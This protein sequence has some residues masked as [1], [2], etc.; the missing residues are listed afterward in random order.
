M[1]MK[2]LHDLMVNE[3]KD[4]YHAENQLLK[5]IPKMAKA[6]SSDELKA[7]FESHLEETQNQIQRLEQVFEEVGIPLRGKKCEAMAGLVE[8]GSE[9]IEMDAEDAVRDAG[10]I[11]AAQKVEHYEIASYGTLRTYAELLGFQKAA[12]LLQET[13]DEEAATDEKLTEIAK[14]INVQAEAMA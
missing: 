5:A 13:L 8:E 4:I 11:A 6:A 14:S 1:K 2:S 7:A 3:L 12:E 10:L 9:M